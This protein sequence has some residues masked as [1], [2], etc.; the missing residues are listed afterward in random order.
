MHAGRRSALRRAGALTVYGALV[1]AGFV[2]P[3]QAFSERDEAVF[4]SST[5]DEAF[6]AL[7]ARDAQRTEGIRIV[8]PDIAEN[9]AMVPIEI[10]V[11]IDGATRIAILVENNP[12]KVAG[13]F[14]FGDDVL[15]EVQTR[16]RLS[17]SS[18]VYVLAWAQGRVYMAR[19]E[20]RVT[21]GGCIA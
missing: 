8:A 9:G 20:V 3:A 19:R 4:S 17:E 10:A 5:L 18:D 21:V 16:I 6:R 2:P 7:S 11:D 14:E 1:L 15:P 12:N 13:I